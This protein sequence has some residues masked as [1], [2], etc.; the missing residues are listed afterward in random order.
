MLRFP[1][2][3]VNTDSK[4]NTIGSISKLKSKEISGETP[5]SLVMGCKRYFVGLYKRVQSYAVKR[6]R[7]SLL[8]GQDFNL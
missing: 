5:L 6:N 3:Q 7:K 1:D 2:D 8:N 4:S